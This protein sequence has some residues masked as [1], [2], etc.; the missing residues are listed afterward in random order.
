MIEGI[1]PY[2]GGA[3]Y[4]VF[5]SLILLSMVT[6]ASAVYFGLNFSVEEPESFMSADDKVEADSETGVDA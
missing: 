3:P 6:I 5:E 2:L 4:P 1:I